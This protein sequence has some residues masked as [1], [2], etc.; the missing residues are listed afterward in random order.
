MKVGLFLPCYIDQFYP[1]VGMDTLQLLERLGLEVVYPTNQTCCGQPIA[2]AGFENNS[3]K[4][5][6]HFAEQFQE[7]DYV[8]SPSGSCVYHVKNH[9]DITP[10]SNAIEK[11]RGN[12]YELCD[13]L[14]NILK[15]TDVG[16]IFNHKV[17]LL[18]SCHGLR[19]LR[20]GKSSEQVVDDYSVCADLLRKVTGIELLNLSRGDEC[21]GFGGTFS[22]TE[23]PLSVKMGSDR[24]NDHLKNGVEVITATDMSCLMHMEGI[25]R[26]R[27]L[28]IRIEH[29]AS[30]LNSTTS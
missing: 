25:I 27:K 20:L 16:A 30:I 8:V 29:I 14:V 19:G 22:I 28:P 7:F 24:I 3:V 2:N 13:F 17:G 23:A 9:Y 4:A 10:D 11:V 6:F 26:R 18:Q 5:A 12:T 1:K 21:C 15:I